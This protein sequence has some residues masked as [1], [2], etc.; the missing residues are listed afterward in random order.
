MNRHERRA[1]K[2]KK[3]LTPDEWK[4]LLFCAIAGTD[5][6]TNVNKRSKCVMISNASGISS[7]EA[8][9]GLIPEE[10]PPVEF[11]ALLHE[12]GAKVRELLEREVILAVHWA[13][14]ASHA[15]VQIIPAGKPGTHDPGEE[16]AEIELP[17]PPEAYRGPLYGHPSGRSAN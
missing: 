14:G 2:A 16:F 17:F 5:E 4:K 10:P 13:E 15:V 1:A 12:H 11:T 3:E 7:G 9:Y 8:I 6:V